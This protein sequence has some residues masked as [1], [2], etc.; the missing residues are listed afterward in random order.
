MNNDF[1][2]YFHMLVQ[3]ERNYHNFG[4]VISKVNVTGIRKDVSVDIYLNFVLIFFI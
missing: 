4:F 3:F 2:Q 1:L